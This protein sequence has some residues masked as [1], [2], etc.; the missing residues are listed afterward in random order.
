ML[1]HILCA[2]QT[3]RQDFRN[4]THANAGAHQLAEMGREQDELAEINL[5]VM[6]V[7]YKSLSRLQVNFFGALKI[8]KEL[9]LIHFRVCS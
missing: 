6:Y 2:L 4:Q 1:R 3:L 5:Y 8:I 7:C 9:P